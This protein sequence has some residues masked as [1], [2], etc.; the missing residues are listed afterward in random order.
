[1]SGSDTGDG[2]KEYRKLHEFQRLSNIPETSDASQRISYLSSMYKH[3]SNVWLV[4]RQL[5]SQKI[6]AICANEFRYS[7]L[8]QVPAI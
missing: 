1:M 6:E 7:T 5:W 4:H 8:L 2:N 3:K